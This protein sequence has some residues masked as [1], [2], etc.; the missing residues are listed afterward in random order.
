[1]N[2]NLCSLWRAHTNTLIFILLDPYF[3][4]FSYS[5]SSFFL[6]LLRRRAKMYRSASW[7]RFSDGD[8]YYKHGPS[9]STKESPSMQRLSAS[10]ESNELP[11]YDP[12]AELA[13]KERARV[14]FAENAVHVIPLV[15]LLCATVLWLF[16]NPGK[17]CQIPKIRP[18]LRWFS[19]FITIK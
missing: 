11:V 15:L 1:M 13:K 18:Y 16:S 12:I 7:S 10:F 4:C 17:L 9:P 8:E 19:H 2:C 14:K 5:L 3:R 6:F